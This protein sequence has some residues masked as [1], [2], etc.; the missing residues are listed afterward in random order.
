MDSDLKEK[1]V[2]IYNPIPTYGDAI[3]TF[4][5]AAAGAALTAGLANT[6]GALV[7]VSGALAADSVVVSL[8]FDTPAVAIEPTQWELSYDA[9]ATVIATGM[10]GFD[11]AVGTYPSINLL[12]T[13]GTIAAGETLQ[14]RIRSATGGTTCNAHCTTMPV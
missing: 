7:N 5:D 1:K 11:T 14:V 4:P 3:E 9:G 6:Y 13:C 2:P 10:I 12:G 8:D